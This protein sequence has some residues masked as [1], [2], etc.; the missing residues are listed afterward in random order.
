MRVEAQ[1]SGTSPR[2]W[3]GDVRDRGSTTSQC[4][5]SG[6]PPLARRGRCGH[7]PPSSGRS[8]AARSGAQFGCRAARVRLCW[9]R[10][11]KKQPHGECAGDRRAPPHPSDWTI[12]RPRPRG[13][14]APPKPNPT[15]CLTV[16]RF[17]LIVAM[18]QRRDDDGSCYADGWPET[19]SRSD[20]IR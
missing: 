8:T 1:D 15:R 18:S 5:A 20:C 13:F 4:V 11:S 7:S 17:L 10:R 3:T 2:K 9:R 12:V 6:G 16:S 14:C 19:R